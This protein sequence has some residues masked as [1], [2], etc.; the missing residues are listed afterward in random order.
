MRKVILAIIL[1]ISGISYALD[2]ECV[3]NA[4][5]IGNDRNSI[6]GKND[7][8]FLFEKSPEI[9][10]NIGAI[11]W[12][13][14]SNTINPIQS[15][16]DYFYP[17]HGEGYAV[18]INGRL[19]VFYVLNYDSLRIQIHGVEVV[20]SCDETELILEGDI[21]QL[22]YRDSLNV[23]Q[24]I[25]RK[26]LVTYMDAAWSESGWVDS[27]VTIE[28]EFKN[29]III[30]SSPIATNY[31]IKDLAA[32]QLKEYVSDA[33]IEVDSIVTDVYQPVAIKAHPQAIV[34]TR[35]DKMENESDRPIDPE[36]LIKRSAPLEV[37]FRANAINAEYYTWNLYQ[38]SDLILTRNEA[39]HKYTF[40]E[41][42]NYS[43]QLKMTNSHGCECQAEDFS[44]SVSESMLN[45]PNVFTPNGDGTHDE[46]RVVYRSIKEFHIWIYNRWG[47]LVYKSND[48]AKGW[49]GTINGRPAAEGAYYYVIRA[50]G[51]DADMDY[52]SKPKYAKKLKKG[53]MPTGVYQLS[54]DINLLR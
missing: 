38:G 48:P 31:V 40:E 41:P 44:I 53:E 7:L 32:E 26:C 9:K 42:T 15:G 4:A 52:M 23:I 37:E 24:T 50:L 14:I 35:S 11:E 1:F 51:T 45:V 25:P 21:P 22:Q 33:S 13:H 49:D 46:F 36:T 54:G 18:K 3:G 30:N 29:S 12:Y 8:V 39:Q 5:I 17:E 2:I 47:H 43:A 34:T 19:L 10:S 28:T 6:L 27:L 20:Q 16:T